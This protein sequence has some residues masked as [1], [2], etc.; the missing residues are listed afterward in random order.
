MLWHLKCKQSITKPLPPNRNVKKK[1][2]ESSVSKPRVGKR[3]KV[4]SLHYVSLFCEQFLQFLLLRARIVGDGS[5]GPTTSSNRHF[6]PGDA[7]RR[8]VANTPLSPE[9]CLQ[10]L[11]SPPIPASQLPSNMHGTPPR[12]TSMA[13]SSSSAQNAASQSQRRCSRLSEAF[14]SSAHKAQS[15]SQRGFSSS[16]SKTFLQSSDAQP[17]RMT[18]RPAGLSGYFN[19]AAR[20]S[21]APTRSGTK[22]DVPNQASNIRGVRG[23]VNRCGASIGNMV[24]PKEA[25]ASASASAVGM[26]WEGDGCHSTRRVSQDGKRQEDASLI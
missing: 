4:V 18:T 2:Q 12:T 17:T 9:A 23:S 7:S 1:S 16:L 5:P 11:L 14:S 6:T 26:E 22:N 15:Q 25:G 10:L 8:P 21:T 13:R 20:Q 3:I 24:E 19:D